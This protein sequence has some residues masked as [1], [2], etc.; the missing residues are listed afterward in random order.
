MG[1]RRSGVPILTWREGVVEGETEE[2]VGCESIWKSEFQAYFPFEVGGV[3]NGSLPM[4][5]SGE[6]EPKELEA[7]KVNGNVDAS[8]PLSEVDG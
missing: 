5:G 6:L 4:K 2:D 1:G 7:L 8:L 3:T